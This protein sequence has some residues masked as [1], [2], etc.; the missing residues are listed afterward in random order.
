MESLVKQRYEFDITSLTYGRFLQ[1]GYDSYP[2]FQ[3]KISTASVSSAMI[4]IM[5]PSETAVALKL[6]FG[7]QLRDLPDTQKVDD[8]LKQIEALRKLHPP[9]KTAPWITDYEEGYRYPKIDKDAWNFYK[10][11]KNCDDKYQAE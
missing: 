11:H 10:Y 2:G 3:P 7:P 1:M 8:L 6:A 5:V 4:D 9:K